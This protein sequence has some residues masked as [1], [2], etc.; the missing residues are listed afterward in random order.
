V[1]GDR[2]HELL[3][4]LLIVIGDLESLADTTVLLLLVVFICVN[5]CALVLRRDPVEHDH[6]RVPTAIPVI[7]AV[8]CLALLVYQVIDAPENLLLAGGLLELGAVLYFVARAIAGPAEPID[9]A[10]LAGD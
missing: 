8:I 2:L 4:C 10:A 1:G 6:F 9:P 3:A 5:V 7:G